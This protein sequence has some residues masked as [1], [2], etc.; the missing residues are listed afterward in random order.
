MMSPKE[1][2][3]GLYSAVVDEN[4][5]IYRELFQ[6]T[7]IGKVTDP[8]WKD[9]LPL[10]KSLSLEQR[11]VFFSII[12]QIMIDTTSNVLGVIDGVNSFANED[13]SL[14]GSDSSKP[15]NGDLQGLFLAEEEKRSKES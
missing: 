14:Y 12:K 2:A 10:F 6:N 5:L 1:F 8:Y 11:E 3:V 4:S 15:L 13:F 7:E 9:A